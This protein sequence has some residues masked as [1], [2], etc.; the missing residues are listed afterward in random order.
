MGGSAPKAYRRSVAPS[1]VERQCL[2]RMRRRPTDTEHRCSPIRLRKLY[3]GYE[4]CG[5][6]IACARCVEVDVPE[7]A[8]ALPHPQS[9]LAGGRAGPSCGARGPGRGF[10]ARLELKAGA[11]WTLSRCSAC[12][13]S[14]ATLWGPSWPQEQS[15]MLPGEQVP[16]L[17]GVAR[18]CDA[19]EFGSRGKLDACLTALE[20]FEDAECG[21]AFQQGARRPALVVTTWMDVRGCAGMAGRSTSLVSA[22]RILMGTVLALL[23]PLLAGGAWLGGMRVYDFVCERR[24]AEGQVE[25]IT[26]AKSARVDVYCEEAARLAGVPLPSCIRVREGMP[27]PSSTTASCVSSTG[28]PSHN[29]PSR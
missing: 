12:V 21:G 2:C 11:P 9:A 20:R 7:G 26:R 23:V 6:G 28:A 25:A 17:R 13:R 27:A 5:R 16:T 4:G 1:V 15:R 3:P 29:S 24:E 22:W 8:H 14:T 18:T 19:R 10:G